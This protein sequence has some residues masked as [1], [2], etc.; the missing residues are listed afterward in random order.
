MQQEKEREERGGT[1]AAVCKVQ[2]FSNG[3]WNLMSMVKLFPNSLRV[4]VFVCVR[5][6]R[7]LI[8]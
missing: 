8:S 7:G 6:W 1:L 5:V 4:C 2:A 3:E